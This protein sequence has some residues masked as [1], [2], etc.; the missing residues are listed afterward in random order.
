[1][2]LAI[3][4]PIPTLIAEVTAKIPT[5]FTPMLRSFRKSPRFA[6]PAVM[7]KK[8]IG[9]T[10]ILIILRKMVPIGLITLAFS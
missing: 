1:M 3:I 6:T 8:T 5:V 7:E 10:I 4:R 2:I 9:T